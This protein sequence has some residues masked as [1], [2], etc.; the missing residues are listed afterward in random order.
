MVDAISPISTAAAA[1]PTQIGTS[2]AIDAAADTVWIAA[3]Q[4]QLMADQRALRRTGSEDATSP[5]PPRHDI[6]ED[7][8]HDGQL[9]PRQQRDETLDE[10]QAGD[11]QPEPA[12]PPTL[13]GESERIGTQNFDED[14]PFGARVAIL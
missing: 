7:A 6:D 1:S 12:E 10:L 9:S 13:S 11:E 8:A 5:N 14:T 2:T 3:R 4:A